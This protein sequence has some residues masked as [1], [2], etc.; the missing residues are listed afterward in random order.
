[1]LLYAR[2]LSFGLGIGLAIG[3]LFG[4]GDFNIRLLFAI[5]AGLLLGWLPG[6]YL[7]GRENERTD[8]N[9]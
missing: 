5:L 8:D 2:T 7:Y 6:W 4:Q 9:N 1:M 3:A